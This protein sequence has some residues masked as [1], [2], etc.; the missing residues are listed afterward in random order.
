[1]RRWWETLGRTEQVAA[2]G[3]AVTLIVGIVAAAPNYVE[4]AQDGPTATT[5]T[6]TTTQPVLPFPTREERDLLAHLP[7]E[8]RAQCQ[9]YRLDQVGERAALACDPSGGATKAWY[10]AFDSA[11]NMYQ[12]YFGVTDSQSI[13]RNSGN[14][15]KDQ[16]AEST[17][18]N[19]KNATVGHLACW[20]EG[21]KSWIIWAHEGL[22]IGASAYRNDLNDRDLFNWWNSAGPLAR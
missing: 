17:Y 1:M 14:C 15:E 9:R 18:R 20:R 16:V 11:S 5:V 4:L 6:T 10:I 12:W 8:W 22:H 3:I 7:K 13:S 2:V 21:Q 19:T